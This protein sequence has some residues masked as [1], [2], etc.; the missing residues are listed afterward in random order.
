[1]SDAGG[2]GVPDAGDADAGDADAE[3]TAPDAA[4]PAGPPRWLLITLAIVGAAALA[5]GIGRFTAFGA[6]S[7][8]VMPT[9][10]SAEA[11]FARDM[12]VHHGQAVEMAMTIYRKTEDPTLKVMAYDMATAQAAQQG[13]M[14]G[15][16]VQWGLP[17][18]GGPLMAWM[19]TGDDG[20]EGHSPGATDEELRDA[21]GMATDE[22]LAALEAASGTEADCLFLEL[23]IRHHEGATEMVDAVLELGTEPRVLV[24]AQGMADVQQ[25]EIDAMRS[26]QARLGCST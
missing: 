21:M 8:P 7:A 12:Q 10:G 4:R 3:R 13:E 25:G 18:K 23:M 22:Q 5:F 24:V 11:G 20:H 6:S 16:L 1:M 14:Y 26:A 19:P 2:A 17:Q 9:T 15:W